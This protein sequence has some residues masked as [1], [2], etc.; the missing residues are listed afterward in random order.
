MCL[1]LEKATGSICHIVA[2][3]LRIR[4]SPSP[5]LFNLKDDISEKTNLFDTHPDIVK[6]LADE[7]IKIEMSLKQQ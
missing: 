4:K 7:M 2:T 5:Q 3:G 6:M 1:A